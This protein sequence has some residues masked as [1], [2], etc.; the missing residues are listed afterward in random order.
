MILK[1][2]FPSLNV[3]TLH[4][5]NRTNPRGWNVSADAPSTLAELKRRAK[6]DGRITVSSL[7]S[8]MTIYGD[9]EVNFAARAWH[10]ACHILAG[11]PFNDEGERAVAELQ[12]QQLR[13]VYGEASSRLFC[14]IVD[15]EVIGQLDYKATHGEFPR[16]QRAFVL[17]HFN[18]SQRDYYATLPEFMSPAYGYAYGTLR[19][20]V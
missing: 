12:K 4:M 7:H 16:D 13:A 14:A 5:A 10:D 18:E 17:D 2:L 15:A 3:A 8:D 9:P 20:F 11:A 6:R 1:P 19:G